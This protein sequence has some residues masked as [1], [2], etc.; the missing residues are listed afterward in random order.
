MIYSL[1]GRLIH[2]QNSVAVIECA[3]VGYS[4]QTT[5]QTLSRLS[6]DTVTLFTYMHI[7]E[8]S[9]DLFGFATHDELEMFKMLISV[10]GVGPKVGLAILN[11]YPPDRL[12]LFIA[13]GDAKMITKAQGVGPKLAQ[14][15]VLELKDKASK[16]LP[17][18]VIAA[19]DDIFSSSSERSVGSDSFSE[20]IGALVSLG[21]NRSEAVSAL[22]GV[23]SRLSSDDMI[24]EALR[25]LA[26]M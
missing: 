22:S 9:L 19:P 11:E 25:K 6:G 24:R 14:R 8:N 12:I 7:T 20:A 15:I 4:C 10:S 18:G 26:R 13:S 21:Y 17:S 16:M 23:D 5:N 3:G 2:K 1:T